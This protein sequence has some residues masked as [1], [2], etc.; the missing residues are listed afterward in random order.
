MNNI[1]QETSSQWVK[2]SEYEFKKAADGMHYVMPA[3]KAKPIIFDP[4]KDAKAMILD[5]LNIGLIQLNRDKKNDINAV[6]DAVI[7]F[8]L[9]YGL[10]GF[11]TALPTTPNFMD[12]D[13]V[14]L[15]RNLFIKAEC[16]PVEEYTALFFPFEKLKFKKSKDG[17]QW[18]VCGDND[19]MALIVAFSKEPMAL[20]MS[21]QRQYAERYDWLLEQFKDWAF[22][23]LTSIL[24]YEDY[25]KIDETAR[26]LYRKGIGAFGG[27]APTYRIGLFDKPTIVWDFN[28]LLLII[29]MMFSFMLTDDAKP[30]RICRQCL[31]AFAAKHP[32]AAFC[33]PRCKN[34]YNAYKNRTKKD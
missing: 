32:N 1:F 20:N 34:Q 28:S 3:P 18:N 5:A 33:S 7:E 24:Y 6:K 31:I 26:N 16:M 17:T 27:I 14:Y 13:A 2:Y 12:Y 8:V 25:D 11:I 30:L 19:M 23:L 9:K 22:I 10:L 15:P 29:Q 4:L 21:F